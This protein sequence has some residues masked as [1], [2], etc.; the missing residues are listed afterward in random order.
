MK[1]C[2]TDWRNPERWTRLDRGRLCQRASVSNVW[3]YNPFGIRPVQT[4]VAIQP[5]VLRWGGR[6]TGLPGS[7]NSQLGTESDLAGWGF[8]GGRGM[9]PIWEYGSQSVTAIDLARPEVAVRWAD[10]MVECFTWAH[11]VHLDYFTDLA[12]LDTERRLDSF[13]WLD[14]NAGLRLAVEH[15][16]KA[17]PDW[18]ILGQQFHLTPIT[19]AVDG[20]F[21]EEHPQHFGITLAQHAAAMLEHGGGPDW[22][23][24]IRNPTV[25]PAGVSP[26]AWRAYL[27]QCAEFIREQGAFV[28]WGRDGAALAGVPA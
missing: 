21:I 27:D 3:T 20:L 18:T 10:L 13:Y 24:E 12:W 7:F 6:V 8:L 22:T 28:S 15:L 11:G 1:T 2:L 14:W 19:D 23:F 9:L 16:R 17:R 4:L 25:P 26:V 5:G